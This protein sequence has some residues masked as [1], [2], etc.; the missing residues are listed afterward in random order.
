MNE[1]SKPLFGLNLVRS[2]RQQE[3]YDYELRIGSRN[4]RAP[5]EVVVVTIGLAL[6]S[7]IL[8]IGIP[9][10][11]RSDLKKEVRYLKQDIRATNQRLTK[12]ESENEELESLTF[13]FK[14]DQGY[15]PELVY[16]SKLAFPL[17][18]PP[19]ELRSVFEQSSC[20]TISY[21]S[22]PIRAR[23]VRREWPSDKLVP[24]SHPLLIDGWQFDKLHWVSYSLH[25]VDEVEIT[26]ADGKSRLSF[27]PMYGEHYLITQ[28]GV[29]L[30]V[31]VPNDQV[32]A[33]RVA[34][35]LPKKN[36]KGSSST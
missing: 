25:R 28:V 27:K 20:G 6:V 11:Q 14:I 33:E 13:H 8:V 24:V 9:Y 3:C 1:S 36:D 34:P 35:P 10:Q 15:N 19:Y 4:V 23:L 12:I 7:L 29:V 32:W 22:K 2:T 26:G 17:A 31:E 21:P 5:L 16:H 18:F 30:K